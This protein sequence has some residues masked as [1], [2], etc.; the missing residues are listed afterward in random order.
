MRW[1]GL[2]ERSVAVV[3]QMTWR[4]VPGESISHLIS[5]PSR[6][7]I[8]N[9]TDRDEPPA[10]V[11]KNDLTIEQLERDHVYDK[12]IQRS[13][14]SSMIAQECLPTL[15]WWSATPDHLPADG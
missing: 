8:G 4:F 11:T 2:A 10:G 13:N 15:G 3:H 9:D 1:I 7:R 5:Y 14:V 12:Q 6:C